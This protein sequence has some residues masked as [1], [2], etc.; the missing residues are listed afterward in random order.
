VK[1]LES[2]S[3]PSIGTNQSRSHRPAQLI[4]HTSASVHRNVN[5]SQEF[6]LLTRQKRA[7]VS[8]I[9]RRATA[10]KR[11]SRHENLL[12][13]WLPEEQFR[14]ISRLRSAQA[15]SSISKKKAR[16]SDLQ[17]SPHPNNRANT[18]ETNVVLRILDRHALGS[19][20]HSSFRSIVPRQTTSGSE[21]SCGSD[22]DEAA[23]IA[24]FLHVGHDYV[25]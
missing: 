8:N 3:L 18:V 25:C 15:P 16:D 22:V 17:S 1:E 7:S 10:T 12:I 21:A 4:S 11:Y 19:I 6:G 23:S 2:H 24:V 20:D 14:P 5:T 13:L 9:L